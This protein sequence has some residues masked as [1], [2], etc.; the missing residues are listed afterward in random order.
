MVTDTI[1]IIKNICTCSSHYWRWYY[2]YVYK[3]QI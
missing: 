1:S 2:I 3:W